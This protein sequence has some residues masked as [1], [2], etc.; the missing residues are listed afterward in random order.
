[1]CHSTLIGRSFQL[2]LRC[3][4]LF[5]FGIVG[6]LAH[7]EASNE[8]QLPAPTASLVGQPAFDF[9]KS[10]E[11]RWVVQGG[12]EGQFGWE[13]DVTSRGSVVIERLKVGTPA[14]MITAYYL[15]NGELIAAHYCQLKNR[16]QLTAVS[17]SDGGDLNLVC[18]G[19]VGN[20]RSH[21]ELHMHGVHF[22]KRGDSLSIWMDMFEKGDVAYT[23]SFTLVRVGAL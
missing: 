2:A 4:L 23:A 20:T 6:S 11:G 5:L 7:A 16:P 8:E 19:A 18:N 14:E 1:M 13:F 17:T 21:A 9:L 3:W 12:D 10:L 15:D 22:Q